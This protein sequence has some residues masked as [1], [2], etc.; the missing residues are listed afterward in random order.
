MRKSGLKLAI[1]GCGGMAEGHLEAYGLIK[2]KEPEKFEFVAM[3][4]PIVESAKRFAEQAAGYQGF[5]PR[6]YAKVSDMLANEMVDVADICTPH[7]EHHTVGIECLNAGVNVM[8]EKPFGV[9]IK[10]SKAIIAAAKNNKKIAATAEN[11]RRGLSQRTSYW[12]LNEAK[13]LGTPRLFYSQ[14]AEWED[15]SVERVWHW[16]VDRW[17][18][19]GGMVMDSGA[20]FCDTIRYLYGD[21]ETIYARVQQLE[22]WPHKKGDAI[23]MDDREDTW[24]ATVTFKSGVVGVWSW[25][26]AAPGHAYTNVVH[27]GSKGCILDHGDAFHGPFGNAEI[28]IQDGLKRIITPM[29]EMQKGFLDQL[30]EAK[31]NALFPHGF[32]EG[33]VIECYDFL[34]A[35]EKKRKPEVDG[36]TG[37]KAKAICE[38]IYESAQIGQAVRYEDVLSGK[39]EE[40]QKP[41]NEHWGL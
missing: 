24:V 9:T 21:P 23:V 19:G 2:R 36:E 25:T 33:V 22:N 32:T 8:I 41:I 37:M 30:D 28:I 18:G 40:Y 17:I 13:L 29:S 20:H 14:H 7:S 15:P 3:C 27:Y 12:I 16:R 11:I 4:D 6:V 39:I 10:A 35:V 1:I 26:M 34:D 31:K 5:K 38:A